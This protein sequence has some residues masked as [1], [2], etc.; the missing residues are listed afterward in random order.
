M[1]IIWKEFKTIPRKPLL[2]IK[3]LYTYRASKCATTNCGDIIHLQTKYI[4]DNFHAY[5]IENI[6]DLN[7]LTNILDGEKHVDDIDT[8]SNHMITVY[9]QNWK[10]APLTKYIKSSRNNAYKILTQQ[11][12]C[13][14]IFTEI[15]SR[16][17]NKAIGHDL[18]TTEI[19]KRRKNIFTL[20]IHSSLQ[21]NKMIASG[22]R[23]P[24]P[25]AQKDDAEKP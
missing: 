22:K 4:Q 10:N 5:E 23:N 9:K 7:T 19:I 13:N 14:E 15:C 3:E 1:S 17:D 20:L 6:P 24:R 2:Q 18:I 12:T 25:N 21:N 16:K 8:D 11:P